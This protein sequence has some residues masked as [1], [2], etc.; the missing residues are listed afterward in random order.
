MKSSRCCHPFER[1]ALELMLFLLFILVRSK[2]SELF[3][4]NFTNANLANLGTSISLK[5]DIGLNMV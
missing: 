4:V 1:K 5:V 2:F 3:A